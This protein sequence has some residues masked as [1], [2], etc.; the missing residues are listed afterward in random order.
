[1]YKPRKLTLLF[2]VTLPPYLGFETSVLIT[3][4]DITQMGISLKH[5]KVCQ[6][7]L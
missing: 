3:S 4:I 5:D 6:Q 7:I 1:M 2:T